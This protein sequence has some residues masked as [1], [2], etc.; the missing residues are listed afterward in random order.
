MLIIQFKIRIF[1]DIV[2]FQKLVF[3]PKVRET[4]FPI[5]TEIVQKIGF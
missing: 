4:R 3:F 1:K 2:T 5:L